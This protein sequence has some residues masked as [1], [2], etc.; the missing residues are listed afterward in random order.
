VLWLHIVTCVACVPCI[1][2]VHGTY[3]TQVTICSRNTYKVLYELYVSTFNEMFNF[4][5][6]LIVAP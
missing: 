4:S 5:E 6:L 3:A 2:T 1:H